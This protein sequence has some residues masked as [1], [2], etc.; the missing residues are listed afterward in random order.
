M[1]KSKRA[2]SVRPE[3]SNPPSPT[4]SPAASDKSTGA[5]A[6]RRPTPAALNTGASPLAAL[7]DALAA[8]SASLTSRPSILPT[9]CK[10]VRSAVAYSPT[11]W[12]L[13]NTVNRSVTA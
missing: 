8:K 1:P 10:R 6:P 7:A 13:R 5:I 4:T 2:V 11:N 3:P 9:S 12:P